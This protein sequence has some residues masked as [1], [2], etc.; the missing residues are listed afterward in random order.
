M[1]KKMKLS[2]D[3]VDPITGKGIRIDLMIERSA[4]NPIH[5]LMGGKHAHENWA[6]LRELSETALR[7]LDHPNL[8]DRDY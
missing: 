4:G 6:K 1:T 2:I 7:Y 8:V 3:K 5:I